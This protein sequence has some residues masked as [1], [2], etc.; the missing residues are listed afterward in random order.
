MPTPPISE[1]EARRTIDAYEAAGRSVAIAARTLGI[2]RKTCHS[3]IKKFTEQ[4]RLGYRPVMEGFVVKTVSS[5]VGDAWVKQAREPGEV[6]EAPANHAIKGVSAL[7]DPDGREM[8]K[9]VKTRLEPS[10]IGVAETLKAAFEGYAPAAPVSVAPAETVNDTLTLL[11]IN[12]PHLG[13]FAWARET[14]QNWDLKIA[15]KVL[16]SAIDEAIARSPASGACVVLG[17][18]DITH[19]D[20]NRNQTARSANPL[21]VDGRHQKV[22]ETAGRLFVRAIDAA[23]LKFQ[24]VH[25]RL[26]K[27]NHDE[28]T[29]PAIAWFLKAWYRNEPRAAVDCDQ[30]LFFHHQFGEVMLSATHG[31]EAKLQDMPGIMAHRRPEMWGA[32]KFRYAHS[33]HVHHKAKM[34]TEGGGVVMESHQAPI[35]QDAWHYGSGFLS[36]RSIGTITYHK[37]FGE[38]SR[39]RVA[40]LDGATS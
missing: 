24:T 31:H 6:F 34:A 2:H 23:L 5:R 27:G 18:G 32:T 1:E 38:V 14:G 4:G 19:A 11:P 13:M 7:L 10:A 25:V 21:D 37:S 16:G 35:P 39:V 40:I 20:N 9:W 22:V 36:G 30:S 8:M 17:G 3:R 15:E 26:L 33:F 29:S 28:E 12:D